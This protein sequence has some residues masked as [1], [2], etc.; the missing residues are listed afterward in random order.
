MSNQNDQH[1]DP[2]YLV[3]QIPTEC[4][5]YAALLTDIALLDLQAG[6]PQD[7]VIRK[8]N[9][10]GAYLEEATLSVIGNQ[11]QNELLDLVDYVWRNDTQ[12]F[13]SLWKQLIDM[14]RTN[15]GNHANNR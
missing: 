11:A 8:L 10:S 2:A 14:V 7:E 3:S 15:R 6:M 1:T 9:Q 12:V 4:L 13:G 5:P